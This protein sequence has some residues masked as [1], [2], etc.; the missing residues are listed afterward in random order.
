MC[1]TSEYILYVYNVGKC[2]LNKFTYFLEI[3]IYFEARNMLLYI[4]KNLMWLK[5]MLSS[6]ILDEIWYVE[7]YYFSPHR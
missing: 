3:H 5:F 4:F 1:T 6:S 2:F 7:A